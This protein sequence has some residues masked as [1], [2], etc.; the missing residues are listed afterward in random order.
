MLVINWRTPR[1]LREDEWL[2][3]VLIKIG[4]QTG[5]RRKLKWSSAV[6]ISLER[7]M[8]PVSKYSRC[9]NFWVYFHVTSAQLGPVWQIPNEADRWRTLYTHCT[10]TSSNSCNFVGTHQLKVIIL[11]CW[12]TWNC[13]AASWSRNSS[14][15]PS[16]RHNAWSSRGSCMVIVWGAQY[17]HHMGGW[18]RDMVYIS[19]SSNLHT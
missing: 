9:M 8:K 18:E 14:S 19:S 3:L 2:R 15:C 4:T 6:G 5:W 11:L 17:G 7:L 16:K 10:T 1:L 12:K 13:S